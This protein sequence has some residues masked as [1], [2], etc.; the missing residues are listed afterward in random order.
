MIGD[1]ITAVTRSKEAIII[2]TAGLRIGPMVIMVTGNGYIIRRL[3]LSMHRRHHRA[4]VSFS[5]PSL[6]IREKSVK[7]EAYLVYRASRFTKHYI[8][9]QGGVNDEV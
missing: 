3:R 9:N 5:H 4:S 2:I 6:F 7:R 8:L 1:M